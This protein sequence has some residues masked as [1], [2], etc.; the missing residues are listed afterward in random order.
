MRLLH[1]ANA[2]LATGEQHKERQGGKSVKQLEDI[3][4]MGDLI[5]N[6]YIEV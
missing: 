1:V 5:K 6:I 3:A 4:E 2:F